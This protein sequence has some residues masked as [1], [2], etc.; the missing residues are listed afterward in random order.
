MPDLLELHTVKKNL[1]VDHNSSQEKRKNSRKKRKLSYNE[2]IWRRKEP[3]Y[4]K[5]QPTTNDYIRS[6]DE[7][8][9][10]LQHLS[11]AEIFEEMFTPQI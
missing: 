8:Q 7:M 10:A 3:E 2:P 9:S 4:T 6:L 11:P 5:I 1:E